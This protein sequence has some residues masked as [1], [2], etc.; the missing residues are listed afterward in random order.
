MGNMEFTNPGMGTADVLQDFDFDSFLHDEGD[1]TDILA[2]DNSLGFMEGE[3]V[4]AE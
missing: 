2:F 4:G 1:G 3:G